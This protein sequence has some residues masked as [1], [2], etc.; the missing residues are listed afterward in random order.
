MCV[1]LE[2][3]VCVAT[4]FATTWNTWR[5]LDTRAS[6]TQRRSVRAEIMRLCDLYPPI[7]PSVCLCMLVCVCL[8]VFLIDL[9]SG[10]LELDADDSTILDDQRLD[11]QRLYIKILAIHTWHPCIIRIII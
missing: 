2:C 6:I 4:A 9:R 3:L 1:W 8:F 11:E 7:D 10:L 5:L